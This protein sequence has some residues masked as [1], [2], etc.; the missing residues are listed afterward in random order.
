MASA[1]FSALMPSVLRLLGT[2]G[3]RGVHLAETVNTPLADWGRAIRSE[4]DAE[5]ALTALEPLLLLLSLAGYG[6]PEVVFAGAGVAQGDVVSVRMP[7]LELRR[8]SAQAWTA[9][10]FAALGL[11]VCPTLAAPLDLATELKAYAPGFGPGTCGWLVLPVSEADLVTSIDELVNGKLW[12][13]LAARVAKATAGAGI[14]A[15]IDAAGLGQGRALGNGLVAAALPELV[16]DARL[17]LG[18]LGAEGMLAAEFATTQAGGSLSEQ[19][20]EATTQAK[21]LLSR[22]RARGLVATAVECLGAYWSDDEEEAEPIEPP[23]M[24]ALDRLG[25]LRA[26]LCHAGTLEVADQATAALL[27]R[28]MAVRR[29]TATLK[30]QEWAQ[31][32]ASMVRIADADNKRLRWVPDAAGSAVG[33]FVR[34]GE[35]TGDAAPVPTRLATT[36]ADAQAFDHATDLDS[37]N[38]FPALAQPLTVQRIAHTLEFARTR[39]ELEAAGAGGTA[40]IKPAGMEGYLNLRFSTTKD[41]DE[42]SAGNSN[43]HEFWCAALSLWTLAAAGYDLEAALL[44]RPDATGHREPHGY[45]DHNGWMPISL[46]MLIDGQSEAALALGLILQQANATDPAQVPGRSVFFKFLTKTDPATGK[47]KLDKFTGLA[48]IKDLTGVAKRPFDKGVA[49]QPAKLVADDIAVG[50]NSL[51][52]LSPYVLESLYETADGAYSGQIVLGRSYRDSLAV[53]Y[54]PGAVVLAGLG[55]S[56]SMA[57]LRPGD[58]GQYHRRL[59][60]KP[61]KYIGDGH[62]FQI[63]SV[64]VLVDGKE[65]VLE[66]GTAATR[67][68]ASARTVAYRCIDANVPGA[69][70]NPGLDAGG[71]GGVSISKWI[72][73]PDP[74]GAP[75]AAPSGTRY[76]FARLHES[77]WSDTNVKLLPAQGATP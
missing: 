31:L 25:L 34:E 29:G 37:N 24:S 8:G 18:Q 44:G 63:W 2:D 6:V 32:D 27:A 36:I 42:V 56:V 11:R 54:G 14:A 73:V 1:S 4:A 23:A 61:P 72:D 26:L 10:P 20:E 30:P 17:R 64:K 41:K 13:L 53:Q 74:A 5:S 75:V 15:L 7:A 57:A 48:C 50:V 60:S 46:R 3:G 19:I 70:N 39:F 47:A 28:L 49:E 21:D 77:P 22:V 9:T 16:A 40:Y 55:H 45:S 69:S 38:R 12:P 62:A 43:C 52:Y 33:R 71:N 68:L 76:Y 51:G 59:A 35:P 67:E 65:V 66:Y 58:L